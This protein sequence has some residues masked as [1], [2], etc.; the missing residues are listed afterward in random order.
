MADATRNYLDMVILM[1]KS[2]LAVL[3]ALTPSLAGA[4][5]GPTPLNLTVDDAVKMALQNNV[6]L[7]ADRLD[8]QIGD[9]RVAAASGLFRPTIASNVQ[10]NNQLQ[11]PSS[12]LFPTS[13]R[14]DVMTSN[15][16]LS[17][18]LPWF[19][20]SYSV[21][22][23]TSHTDSNSFL[24]SYNPLLRSGLSFQVSQ[25]LL[26]DLFTDSAR[27]N[28]VLSKTNRNIADT[29][30][31]ESVVHTTAAVR[32][33]YWNLVSARAN[34]EARLAALRLAEELVRVNKAKVDVG[35]SPPIDLLSAQ[36]EV[37]SNQ[38]QLIVAETTVKQTEDRLRLLIFDSSKRDVWNV[39]I[40]P[41]DTP[42]AG[43]A[44]IDVEA[45][46]TNALRD[47]AD[48]ARTR[49]DIQNAS[50]SLRLSGNQK[51]P[52]VRV[53]ASYQA[54]GLG[55]TEILRTGGFP[56]TITGPGQVVGFGTILDQLFRSD[57][58][59]WA[60]G[61]SVSYPIGQSAEEANQVRSRLE[62]QQAEQRARSAEGRA[63][64]Q[65]RDA[66]WKVEMNARRL[67][68]VRAGR[69]LAEQR[70]D[71]EQKRFDVGMSTSFLVIQAQRDL[72]QARQNELAA[73]LAYD[74]SL[75][76]F[77]ALQEAGP[78]GQSS[79]SSPQPAVTTTSNI[80]RPTTSTSVGAAG[81]TATAGV[82]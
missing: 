9:T 28:V 57:Y 11:P 3:L 74:L 73:V 31:Q 56:G 82:F 78:A 70:R 50:T 41:I 6:D 54:S 77:E 14:N 40:E 33:A 60:V 13:T 24:N 32:A 42:P 68:T 10:R 48:L 80:S 59:T 17:Q 26:K 12:L 19:G 43:T 5:T 79:G 34:V 75:V 67:E 45:A 51:L 46:V 76:D 72:A 69:E 61:V 81:A 8:P 49:M 35:Q 16:G 66:A 29:R 2:W 4:Q 18:R 52:D 53:N 27:T 58:P 38:E 25:P 55:G 39:R 15:V 23:D 1:R 71:V 37:A 7:A 44:A 30:L 22:W 36:A 21:A 65:V 63:I 20:T 62:S 47:R 64:Q